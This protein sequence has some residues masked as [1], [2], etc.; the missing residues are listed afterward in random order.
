MKKISVLLCIYLFSFLPVFSQTQAEIDKMLKEAK[1]EI[2]KL[3]KDPKT[4]EMAKNMLNIDSVKKI[5]AKDDKQAALKN[6]KS[7]IDKTIKNDTTQF[8]LPSRNEKYLNALPIRT[9][10][11]EELVSYLHNLKSKLTEILRNSY[12]TDI[13]KIPVKIVCLTGS[14]IALWMNGES[15]ESVLLALKGAEMLPDN[16]TLLNNV[17]GI[18]TAAGLGVNAIPVLQYALEKQPE[19][20]MILNNLGQAYFSLG[21]YKKAEGYLIECIKTAQYFPDANL[22]LAY[23]NEGRGNKATAITYAENS[24]RGAYHP[25]AHFLLLKLNPKAK[26]MDYIRHRY[27]QPEYF[28]YH[29]YPLLAQCMTVEEAPFLKPQ[30]DGLYE[31]L[32][33]HTEKYRLLEAKESE[34]AEKTQPEKMMKAIKAN[35][36]PYRPFGVFANAVLAALA[37]ENTDK[38]IRFDKYKTNYNEQIKKLRDN[39]DAEI[40]IIHER[41]GPCKE[42]NEVGNKYLPQFASLRVDYQLKAIQLYSDFL[43]DWSYWS[44]IASVEDHG[45]KSVFYHLVGTMLSVLRDVNTTE[46]ILPC[47]FEEQPS[48]MADS[49]VIEAPPCFLNPTVVLPYG[50]V[51]L[52]ISC[53]GYKLEAGEG[54]VGKFE[55]NSFSGD[56]TIAFGVG[57]STPILEF[58]NKKLGIG[59]KAEA[60]AKS[61]FFITIDKS[62][63][64][65]DMGVLWEAEI[66][67]VAELG[68]VK[69]EVGYGEGVTV[70]FGSGV[71]MKDKGPIKMLIDKTYYVQPDDKQINKKVPLYKK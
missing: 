1:V 28:N 34:L 57:A 58:G 5:M 6:S 29:K 68:E 14:S 39:Y 69:G 33:A 50:L 27:K 71:Q 49:L 48:R 36:N 31:M 59:V 4:A 37:E 67:G 64:P 47:L 45:Y 23:I 52:E 41:G 8:V 20:N 12:S 11:R 18:L 40:N 10:T 70:G 65:T 9:F 46:L 43:N 56:M 35:R 61:Q 2:D 17:G 53:E 19:N 16:G 15:R 54:F 13:N 24:L 42:R 38:F 3:K 30:Y 44:Y 21:D 66:K 51:N 25:D 55:Y 26:L 7:G 60:E 22:A 32:S 63:H 62:G